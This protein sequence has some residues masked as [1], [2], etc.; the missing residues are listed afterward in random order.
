MDLK[1][2]SNLSVRNRQEPEIPRPEKEPKLIGR[3]TARVRQEV[4][5][6]WLTGKVATRDHAHLSLDNELSSPSFRV[7][8]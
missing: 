3:A 4:F 8:G 1:S 7:I 6:Q 2:R 5:R